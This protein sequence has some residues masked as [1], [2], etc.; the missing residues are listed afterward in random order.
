MITVLDV[1]FLDL[2][3]IAFQK[4]NYN[5]CHLFLESFIIFRH[6]NFSFNEIYHLEYIFKFSTAPLFASYLFFYCLLTPPTF[7]RPS[8]KVHDDFVPDQPS[9]FFFQPLSC[10]IIP[11]NLLRFLLHFRISFLLRLFDLSLLPSS[12]SPRHHRPTQSWSSATLPT[13]AS[14]RINKK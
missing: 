14:S 13:V 4:A 8:F 7:W 1:I 9:L 11:I 2:K 5:I 6:V 10:I 12:S 3:S